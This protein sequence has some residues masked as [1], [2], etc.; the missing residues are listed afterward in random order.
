M[1]LMAYWK[2]FLGQVNLNQSR[3]DQLDDRVTTITNFLQGANGFGA[4]A[5]DVIPQGSYAQRTIIKPVGAH[6]FD[7]DVLLQMTEQDGWEPG[8]YVAKLYTTFRGSSTYK[9]LVG[10]RTRCVVVNYANEFHVDVVPYLV[11]DDGHWITN[12][13]EN[14]LENTNP[15]GFN[16]WL[17]A[18]DRI[19]ARRLVEVIRVMKYLRDFKQTFS[20]RS[21]VL[22]FLL[23]NQV[24]ETRKLLSPGCYSDRPTAFVTL[25][26]DLDTWLQARAWLPTL[27]DP[28]CPSQN[29]H[30]RWNQ[31][32]YANFR[33]KIHDYAAKAR[34]AYGMPQSD[35]VEASVKA[36]QELFGAKFCKPP[37][38]K[39]LTEAASASV[40]AVDG[41]QDIEADLG[42][43]ISP[44]TSYQ[45]VV[46]G[47]VRKKSDR[48]FSYDLAKHGNRVRKHRSLAFEITRCTVPTPYDTYWKVRN[49]GEEAARLNVLRG[50]IELGNA[51]RSETTAYRGNH[52]VEVYIVK[53][54]RCVAIDRQ[55]V[56]VY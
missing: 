20:V 45:V 17:D 51:Y 14:E 4:D 44:G 6:E 33:N 42:F 38:A 11:R 9:D 18:R 34:K 28:S 31:D 36:W 24:S 46:R 13:A 54:G 50:Q 1:K 37:A 8:D 43:S 29:F 3:I 32:E 47:R 30:D 27:T 39:A 49:D 25:L 5:E 22:S 12:R 53:D 2:H 40:R 16:D 35:G 23:A 41:E 48:L 19:T 21:V 26:E 52:Y 10:R 7:A 55:R 56:T 15:E